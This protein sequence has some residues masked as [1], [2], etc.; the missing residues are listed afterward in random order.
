MEVNKTPTLKKKPSNKLRL[1]LDT[2]KRLQGMAK[3]RKQGKGIAGADTP[4]PVSTPKVKRNT[5]NAPPPSPVKFKKRQVSKTWLPTHMYHSKRAHM[6][7]PSSPLWRFAIPIS[8]NEKCY[9]P[10]HRASTIRGAVAW[11]MSY[12][13]TIGLHGQHEA[14]ERLLRALGVGQSV[15]VWGKKGKR[16]RDGKR[17]WEGWMHYNESWPARAIAPVTIIWSPTEGEEEKSKALASNKKM[18]QRQ[19]FIRVHPSA[20]LEVW[21]EILKLAKQQRPNVAVEDLRFEIGSIEITGP[22]STEALVSALQ[23]VLK[24]GTVPDTIAATW[25]SLAGLTNP[26]SLP[27]NALLSFSVTDPRL[28]Y[29]PRTVPLPFPAEH[30]AAE[31]KL[32]DTMAAWPVDQAQL[33][34]SLFSR[35]KRLE[36]SRKLPSQKRINL[37]KGLALAGAYPAPLDTD[38]EIP[39]ILLASRNTTNSQGQGK[40]SLLLPWKCVMPVWYSLM[41]YPLSSGGRSR[42]GALNEIRQLAFESGNPWFPGDYPGTKAG[43][44]M[45]LREEEER[46]EAWARKPRGK[47]IEWASLPLGEGRKGEIGV[48]WGCDWER[49][50]KGPPIEVETDRTEKV[51]GGTVDGDAMEVDKTPIVPE[52]T[53]ISRATKSRPDGKKKKA[54]RPIA[55]PPPAEPTTVFIHLPSPLISSLLTNKIPPSLAALSSSTLSTS[56]F[57]IKIHLVHRGSPQPCA[58][59]YRLPSGES[60]S[61]LRAKWLALLTCKNPPKPLSESEKEAKAIL[62]MGRGKYDSPHH[63]AASLLYPHNTT[64]DGP[65]EAGDKDYPDVPGEEDLIGFVTSGNFNLAEGLGTGVGALSFE[66][67]FGSIS[68]GKALKIEKFCIVRDAGSSLGRLA[69]WDV[70][71]Q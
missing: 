26:A 6:S 51:T 68:E 33:S 31:M 60:K 18:P 2:A 61:L 23:P 32:L 45:G 48:G 15:D 70:V 58:R 66:K 36:A 56:L 42:F 3:A 34:A 54:S 71:G 11:D 63:L 65:P 29:P 62:Q 67:V 4:K 52:R 44:A 57:T 37:R 20:F 69:R 41:H 38:P 28:R 17:S 21:I 8:P 10:T 39:I 25:T 12:M 59:I 50:I 40:W 9:R 64:R 7:S 5:L 46:A 43:M 13:S 53:Q 30:G 16:W 47:R 27:G 14:I 35:S 24:A 1:R 49:L 55:V 19:L 22:A